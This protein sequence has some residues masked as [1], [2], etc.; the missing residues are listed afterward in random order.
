[1]DEKIYLNT[2]DYLPVLG[3]LLGKL[4]KKIRLD[5]I[6]YFIQFE[7][8]QGFFGYF[9]YGDCCSESWINHI[10]GLQALIGEKVLKVEK[11]DMGEIEKG[12]VGFSGK[13]YLEK[14]YSYKIFTSQGICEIEMRN[15][16]NGYYGGSLYQTLEVPDCKLRIVHEDF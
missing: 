3:A 15:A 11:V 5:M 1:M 6:N 8:D 16:S 10:S 7:T 9:A 14:I 4:I 2:D 13:Q 12:Q